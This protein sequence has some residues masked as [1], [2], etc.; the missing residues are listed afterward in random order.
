MKQTINQSVNITA[1]GFKKNLEAYPLRM[2]YQG[3]VYDFI[4]SGLRCIIRQGEQM[5]QILTMSDGM[6]NF[7]LRSDNK[8]GSWTL[9][10]IN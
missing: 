2:E 1:M 7:K 5:A 4:D 10:S 9:V 8:G 6:T 3:R